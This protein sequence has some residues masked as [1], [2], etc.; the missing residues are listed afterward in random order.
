MKQESLQP[1]QSSISCWDVE[2]SDLPGIV[3][4]IPAI[5][6]ITQRD[7]LIRFRET[8]HCLVTALQPAGT[9][10]FKH[11]AVTQLVTISLHTH[12][13]VRIFHLQKKVS[14]CTYMV[15]VV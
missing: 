10:M 14:L 15:Y 1:T 4:Q 2:D 11:T 9:N 13:L 5:V 8:F 3:K 7:N 12:I 6:K